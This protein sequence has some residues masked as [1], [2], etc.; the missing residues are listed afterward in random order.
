MEVKRE[1]FNVKSK[2]HRML[3]AASAKPGTK[4]A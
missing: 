4:R 3:F 1:M 2:I